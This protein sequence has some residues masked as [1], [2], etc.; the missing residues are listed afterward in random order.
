MHRGSQSVTQNPSTH[1]DILADTI[2]AA[3][4]RDGLAQK[5][6]KQNDGQAH[7]KIGDASGPLGATGQ[8]SPNEEPGEGGISNVGAD[9]ASGA[10]VVT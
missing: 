7:G 3:F 9:Y 6:E 1:P 8:A 10:S 4:Q 5:D 2:L